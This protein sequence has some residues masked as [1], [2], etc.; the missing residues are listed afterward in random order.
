MNDTAAIEAALAAWQAQQR[1]RGGY[2]PSE[3]DE[4]TDHV[5]SSA[6]E[7]TPTAAERVQLAAQRVGSGVELAREFERVRGVRLEAL[8]F[9]PAGLLP[10]GGV[11]FFFAW[12]L[13]YGVKLVVATALLWAFP[14][15]VNESSL[16]AYSVWLA[17]VVLL[18]MLLS[19]E[20][21]S[22]S[23]SAQL[24]THPWRLLGA[25]AA[26][27]LLAVAAGALGRLALGRVAD[28]EAFF[29]VLMGPYPEVHLTVYTQYILIPLLL[30]LAAIRAARNSITSVAAAQAA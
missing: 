30:F 15:A 12:N 16:V 20:P 25:S 8:A 27:A 13:A 1:L 6:A 7:L 10:A 18:T 23:I 22:R 3:L 11:F 26:V 19:S 24:R 14:N 28:S 21:T 2:T 4:L 17:V 9:S 5:R 29:R